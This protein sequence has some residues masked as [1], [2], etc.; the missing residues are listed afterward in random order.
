MVGCRTNRGRSMNEN[1]G[2]AIVLATGIV[3]ASIFIGGICESP[4]AGNAA[5]IWRVNRFT[6]STVVCS[7]VSKDPDVLAP[8]CFDVPFRKSN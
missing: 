8:Q 5:Y 6:G 4:S 3:V 2:A 7:P 1:L